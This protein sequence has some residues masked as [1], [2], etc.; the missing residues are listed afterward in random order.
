MCRCGRNVASAEAVLDLLASA[1]PKQTGTTIDPVPLADLAANINAA[2][3]GENSGRAS[4]DTAAS[5]CSSDASSE[6][7]ARGTLGAV[8]EASVSDSEIATVSASEP[9]Q[10]LPSWSESADGA[11]E[12]SNG[13]GLVESNKQHIWQPY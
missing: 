3:S 8:A 2:S 11:S 1:A 10:Q 6:S 5:F 13:S 7:S 12:Q 4:M 9:E